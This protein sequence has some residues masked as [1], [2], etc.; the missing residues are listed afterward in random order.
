MQKE[1]TH[2]S[3]IRNTYN[4]K[5]FNVFYKLNSSFAFEGIIKRSWNA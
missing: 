3:V 2:V 4:N 1:I 5:Q